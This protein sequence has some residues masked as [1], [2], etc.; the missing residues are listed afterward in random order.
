MLDLSA[1]KLIT[2]ARSDHAHTL[3]H[4]IFNSPENRSDAACGDDDIFIDPS[5]HSLRVQ[6]A[7]DRRS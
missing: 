4:V 5:D 2:R 1:T 7:A 3:L 6:R